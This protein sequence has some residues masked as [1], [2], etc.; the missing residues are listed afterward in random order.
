MIVDDKYIMVI[1]DYTADQD[2]LT[3]MDVEA[4]AQILESRYTFENYSLEHE[5]EPLTLKSYRKA[6]PFHCQ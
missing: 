4:H 3:D 2:S 6:F 1:S 5:L